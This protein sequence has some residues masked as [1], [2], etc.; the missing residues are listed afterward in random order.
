MHNTQDSDFSRKVRE[1]L[2]RQPQLLQLLGAN[3]N[4]NATSQEPCISI[5]ESNV[6][7]DCLGEDLVDEATLTIQFWPRTGEKSQA[8]HLIHSAEEAL[9]S[10]GLIGGGASIQLRPEFAGARRLPD[11]KEYHAI[12][13]YRAVRQKNAA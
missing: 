4:D 6:Q 9:K 13:R 12:L 2:Q 1:A 11:E 5:G 3:A 10:A 8:Q 7:D